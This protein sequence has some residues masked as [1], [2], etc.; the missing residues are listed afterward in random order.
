M[1]SIKFSIKAI[2]AA[3]VLATSAVGAHAQSLN[4]VVAA[5][6]KDASELNAENQRRL[7][8]FQAARN[9]QSAALGAARAELRALEQRGAD[10]AAQLEANEVRLDELNQELQEKAGDF[11]ELL[12][13]FRTAAGEIDPL[14]RRSIISTEYPGRAEA[15]SE[16]S[17]ARTLP[18]RAQLDLL[19]KA[20]L[21][22]A[23]G[24]AEV[25]TYSAVVANQN[26][27][28]PID[29]M[30]IGPF[31]AFTASGSPQFLELKGGKLIAFGAQP[32]GQTMAGA[33]ALVGAGEGQ[34]V[35]APIDPSQ[36]DLLGLLADM[37]NLGDRIQQGGTPGYI[38]LGLLVIGL[39]LS[40]YKLITLL[41]ESSAVA[42][43]AKTKQAGDGNSLAR[44][45]R[46]YDDARDD[47]IEALELRLDE[48]I[49]K[50]S[51][52]LD[53]FN[54]IIKVLAAVA[55]LLGLLGTVVGMIKTFT[56]ITLVG[57]GDPKTMAGGISQALVTTVEGLVAAIPLILLHAIVSSQSKGVQQIIEEQA[58]GMI[59]EHAEANKGGARV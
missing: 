47:D 55:P 39:L 37:P 14:L 9:E 12:G 41:L 40:L 57:T 54:N 36:G 21:Q 35:K 28:E 45:F 2:A 4:D 31:T 51:A 56:Q 27:N 6:R 38:V 11:S 42:R 20:M 30:R 25:K 23:V 1:K 44:V 49:L 7:S 53:R 32:T 29:V 34:L 3:A 59:A 33:K 16:I 43:T 5:L 17:Q 46:A 58:A 26:N 24:Q 18:N 15:L 8:E 13:Q 10:L 19:W 48:Q 52:K 22:E 50:E